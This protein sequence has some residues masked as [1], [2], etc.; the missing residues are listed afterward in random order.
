VITAA[1]L[2]LVSGGA[3]ADE[4]ETYAASVR[5]ELQPLLKNPTPEL[6]A[7]VCGVVGYRGAAELQQ[8]TGR[9]GEPAKV[10]AARALE[11]YCNSNPSLPANAIFK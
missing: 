7:A 8:Q 5:S 11:K 6:K 10:G 3:S 2:A 4:F 1:E 9:T